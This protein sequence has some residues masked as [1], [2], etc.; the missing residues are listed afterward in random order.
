M[1][2]LAMKR[3]KPDTETCIAAAIYAGQVIIFALGVSHDA[4]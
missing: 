2:L 3:L 1:D 4:F